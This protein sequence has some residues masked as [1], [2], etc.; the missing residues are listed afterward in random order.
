[1]LKCLWNVC[2]KSD[3]LWVKWIHSYYLK[4][5]DPLLVPIGKSWSW[6]AQAVLGTRDTIAAHPLAW[7]KQMQS[8]RFS[9]TDIYQALVK[10]DNMVPWRFLM[11][12]NY[13]R[14]KAIITLWLVCHG[15]LATKDRLL[16][17]GMLQDSICSLCG[18][19]DESIQHLFFECR[20]TKPIWLAILNWMDI[21]HGP[22]GWYEEPRL[23]NSRVYSD[24]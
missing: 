4:N 21:T 18:E 7:E 9:M 23:S 6:V 1:M 10:E 11:I 13:A 22:S 19:K 2:K 20:D 17:F 12:R 3:N 16:R 8:S 14:P 5:H 15:K 24:S